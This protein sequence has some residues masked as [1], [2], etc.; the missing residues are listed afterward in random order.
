MKSFVT[1]LAKLKDLMFKGARRQVQG[2]AL[3]PLD[4]AFQLFAEHYSCTE[5]DTESPSDSFIQIERL[6]YDNRR[7]CS[8]GRHQTD[9]LLFRDYPVGLHPPWKNSASVHADLS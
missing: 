5:S 9:M 1:P 6:K 7:W 4:F 2:G 3:A 8:T